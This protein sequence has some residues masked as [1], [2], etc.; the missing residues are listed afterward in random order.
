MISSGFLALLLF[1]PTLTAVTLL[2]G[3]SVGLIIS[4]LTSLMTVALSTMVSGAIKVVV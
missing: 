4:I 3:F 1:I 2:G